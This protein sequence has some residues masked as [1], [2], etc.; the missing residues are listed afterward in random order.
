MAPLVWANFP[1]AP[2]ALLFLLFLL[3]WAGIPLRMVLR[4]PDTSPDYAAAHPYLAAKTALATGGK[5]ETGCRCSLSSANGTRDE[6]RACP[7]GDT[8]IPAL[9]SQRWRRRLPGVR[10]LPAASP[11]LLAAA[12]SGR[13]GT[14]SSRRISVASTW[15]MRGLSCVHL[16]SGRGRPDCTPRS[17][18][19]GAGTRSR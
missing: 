17:R 16:S 4:H 12:G 7:A 18:W 2:L 19:R 11:M 14:T 10:R 8:T 13:Q 6:P 3:A 9:A 15:E 5:P 1:L